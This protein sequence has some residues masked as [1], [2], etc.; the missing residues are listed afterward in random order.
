MRVLRQSHEAEMIAEFLQQEYASVDRYRALIE[1]ALQAEG[2]G[3]ALITEADISDDDENAFRRRLFG[4]YRGYGTGRPSYL[5]DF[6]DTGVQWQWVALSASELLDSRF[7]RYPFWSDLSQ[8]TRSPRVAADRIVNDPTTMEHLEDGIRDR[9][10]S[11]AQHIRDG[12]QMPPL[13]LVSADEGATRVVLE[14]HTRLTA[15][16]LAADAIPDEV[17]ALLGLSSDI[18]NWDEY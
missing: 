12:Q 1:D 18:T 7:I 5:T 10:L 16:A 8:G 13:I 2:V 6:P 11:L 17:E 3:P 9:F 4:R 14:G 15:Y